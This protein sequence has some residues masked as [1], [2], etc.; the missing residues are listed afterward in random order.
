[1]FNVTDQCFMFPAAATVRCMNKLYA[2]V[3]FVY[4]HNYEYNIYKNIEV[5]ICEILTISR[6]KGMILCA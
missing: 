2:T 5:E 6:I 4:E 1:M 3:F